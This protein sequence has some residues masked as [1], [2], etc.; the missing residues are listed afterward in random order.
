MHAGPSRKPSVRSTVPNMLTFMK[1]SSA[2]SAVPSRPKSCTSGSGDARRAACDLRSVAGRRS[3][4]CS[5]ICSPE[6]AIAP[7]AGA[8]P[9]RCPGRRSRRAHMPARPGSRTCNEQPT[10]AWMRTASPVQ[11]EPRDPGSGSEP[12]RSLPR[13]ESSRPRR[14]MS[15]RERSSRGITHHA[16]CAP[17]SPRARV[18]TRVSGT[19]G[20]SPGGHPA[21]ATLPAHT[22]IRARG[23]AGPDRTHRTELIGR[24]ALGCYRE[25]TCL[26]P[27]PR[28][29]ASRF[30]SASGICAYSGG[31]QAGVSRA[32]SGATAF[33]RA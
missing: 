8:C 13:Y 26:A 21:S 32:R 10:D 6:P 28:R 14:D 29:V 16:W 9:W 27:R 23:F 2:Y 30:V 12:A 7:A 3:R 1:G 22:G 4:R 20:D 5:G 19:A 17:R 25:S 11:P 15:N 24:P 33:R 18:W 31:C